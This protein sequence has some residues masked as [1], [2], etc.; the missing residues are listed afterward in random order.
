M[1]AALLK[2]KLYRLALRIHPQK[3]TYGVR[4]SATTPGGA[5]TFTNYN[6]FR[7]TAPQPAQDELTLGGV[8]VPTRTQTWTVYQADLDQAGAPQPMPTYTLTIQATGEV[9]EIE[10]VSGLAMNSAW[11]CRCRLNAGES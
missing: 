5:D 7:V 3:A 9:W 1:N 8:V 6:L 2:A 11:Q 4:V 10:G